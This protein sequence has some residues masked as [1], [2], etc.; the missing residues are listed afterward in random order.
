MIS[1]DPTCPFEKH[2]MFPQQQQQFRPMF[3]WFDV[4]MILFNQ[5]LI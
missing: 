2:E 3:V 1:F 5:L 4:C